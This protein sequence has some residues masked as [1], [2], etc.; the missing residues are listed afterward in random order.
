MGACSGLYSNWY[1]HQAGIQYI[2]HYLDDFI[3]ITPPGSPEGLK[4]LSILDQVCSAL[5]VPI[6]EHK[7]LVWCSL[8]L[9]LTPPRSCCAFQ[10]TS[11]NDYRPY[12]EEWD[13]RKSCSHK[14]LES[15]I[16]L[17]NHL[18]KVVHSGRSSCT[19][20][21][22]WTTA[23]PTAASPSASTLD[24]ALTLPGGEHLSA[25]GG[26]CHSSQRHP[27]PPR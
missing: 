27:I 26:G 15:L 6:A 25:S 16:G 20:C 11:S 4:C 2:I 18:C 12:L 14:E 1:L 8:A 23:Q 22:V 5:R 17:L 24:F 21:T 3:V 13:G 10:Q 9:K 19:F 7:P